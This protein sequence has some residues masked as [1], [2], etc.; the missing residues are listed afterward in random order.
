[1]LIYVF[2]LVARPEIG[3]FCSANTTWQWIDIV[4]YVQTL[5]PN[6]AERKGKKVRTLFTDVPTKM[7]LLEMCDG[8]TDT[9]CNVQTRSS[10]KG[11]NSGA[12]PSAQKPVRALRLWTGRECYAVHGPHVVAIC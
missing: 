3:A 4:L 1:M 8:I 6:P 2:M 7:K 11:T 9:S 10:S 5:S 12:G